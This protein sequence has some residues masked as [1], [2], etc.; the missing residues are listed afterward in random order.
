MILGGQKG[1]ISPTNA[2]TIPVADLHQ[3]GRSE[4]LERL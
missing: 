1:F 4:I 3:L 2:L